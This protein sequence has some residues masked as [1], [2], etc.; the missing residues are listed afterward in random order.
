M[1]LSYH[2]NILLAGIDKHLIKQKLPVARYA[3]ETG[4]MKSEK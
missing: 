3:T 4:D 2:Q 1:M